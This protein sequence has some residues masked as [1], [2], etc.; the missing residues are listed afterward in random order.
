MKRYRAEEL[1]ALTVDQLWDLPEERHIVVFTDGDVLTHTRATITSVYLWEPLRHVEAPLLKEYHLGDEQFTSKTMLKLINRVIWGIHAHSGETI[2]TEYLSKLAFDTSNKFYNDFTVRLSAYVTTLSMFDMLEVMY[3]PDIHK[4]NQEVQ[5]TEHSIEEVTYKKISEVLKDPQKLRGNPVSETV[6]SGTL[7]MGQILQCVGPRGYITDINGD[8]FPEPITKGYMEGIDDLYGAMIESRM[9]TKSTLYN[10]ELLSDTQYFN[11]R[12]QLVAQYVQRLHMEDCGSQELIPF[13]VNE[14]LLPHLRGKYYHNPKTQQLEWLRGDET[15]LIGETIAMRS[16]L[17]CV[18]PDPSG[19]CKICY[20][21]LAYNIPRGT[22]IGH[23][24]AVNMGDKIT[25]TV[26]STKHLDSSSKVE[27]FVIHKTEAK[28]LCYYKEPETLYLR[29]ELKGKKIKIIVFKN[30]VRS[31][32][33]VRLLS[34]LRDYPAA[35]ASQIT[36]MFILVD[37]GAD[38]ESSDILKVSLYNRKSSFSNELLEH[39]RKVHWTYD[40]SDN[41]VIDL[42][43]F[44][45]SKPFLVL[46]YKHVNMHE[47]MA[48]VRSFLYSGSDNYDKRL[49]SDMVENKK[50]VRRNFLK[51]YKDPVEGLFVFANMLNEKLNINLVH[52]EILI[53]AMMIRSSA[54]RDYRLPKPGISGV[55]EKYNTIMANRSLAGVMAY[56]KQDRALNSPRS[57][58]YTQRSDHPYDLIVKGGVLD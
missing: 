27:K 51:N 21:R 20:G 57:F 53:Y 40:S 43:G 55:F 35:N 3:H 49:G 29:K 48:R 45:V 32:A 7:S 58:I 22:N 36:Q 10:K 2:D 42:T 9:G 33:D 4:A 5:P 23:V 17:G 31:L 1:L 15:H 37:N 25:S 28:Y 24:S 41:V 44:D 13:P 46:P 50:R 12:T 8:L 34:D 30:E 6:R 38:G 11:R 39:I 14:H 52:C 16:V 47:V 26:L 19:I 18:H 56:E 54:L